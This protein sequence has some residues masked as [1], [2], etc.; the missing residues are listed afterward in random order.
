MDK[1][2][3][4]HTVGYRVK[5]SEH[6]WNPGGISVNFAGERITDD[7]EPGDYDNNRNYDIHRGDVSEYIFI[8]HG[9]RPESIRWNR[10][11]DKPKLVYSEH[12]IKKANSGVWYNI[13][14]RNIDWKEAT[15]DLYVNRELIEEDWTINVPPSGGIKSI[16]H[17]NDDFKGGIDD[18]YFED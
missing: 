9:K 15:A 18:I 1:V 4:P 7:D 8:D 5:W 3:R 16:I 6:D 13:E 10:N 12:V 2:Y 14:W 11:W 17:C